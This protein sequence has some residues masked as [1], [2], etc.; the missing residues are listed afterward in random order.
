MHSARKL[1]N[2]AFCQVFFATPHGAPD[3]LSA[4]W[5]A[6][7]SKIY[8]A[9]PHRIFG[10]KTAAPQQLVTD[11]DCAHLDEISRTFFDICKWEKG[12]DLVSF[13][14]R[15]EHWNLETHVSAATDWF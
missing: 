7:A 13:E 10:G 12:I 1:L 2:T 9:T 11:E 6:I 3:A 4:S 8:D 14:E 5:D 15:E